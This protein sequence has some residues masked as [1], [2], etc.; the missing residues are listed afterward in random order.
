MCGCCEQWNE[1]ITAGSLYVDFARY[2]SKYV[3]NMPHFY[4]R[5]PLRLIQNQELGSLLVSKCKLN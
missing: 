3:T 1:G 2:V 4:N 5:E